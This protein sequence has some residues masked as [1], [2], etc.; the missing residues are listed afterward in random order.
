[1]MCD[2]FA[3]HGTIPDLAEVHAFPTLHLLVTLEQVVDV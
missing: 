1:M 2:M 3:L